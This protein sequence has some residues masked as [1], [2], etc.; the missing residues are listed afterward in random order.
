M[1]S[2][3]GGDWKEPHHD[4]KKFAVKK[5]L[6]MGGVDRGGGRSQQGGEREWPHMDV[7]FST[8]NFP[9]GKRGTKGAVGKTGKA[10]PKFGRRSANGGKR[11]S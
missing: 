1:R 3:N 10:K 5:N 11:L 6:S 7:L 9:R 2:L 8:K 4:A